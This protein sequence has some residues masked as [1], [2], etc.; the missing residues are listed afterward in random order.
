MAI[1]EIISRVTHKS[2]MNKTK[3]D[4]ADDVLTVMD[5]HHKSQQRAEKADAEVERLKAENEELRKR[6]WPC[7]QA[8]RFMWR[9][10]KRKRE[11]S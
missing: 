9:Y 8:G 4:L 7:G 11:E 3:W 1:I 5:L 6:L 10:E 2:L